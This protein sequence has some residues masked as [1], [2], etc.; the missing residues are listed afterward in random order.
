MKEIFREFLVRRVPGLFWSLKAGSQNNESEILK[1]IV[2]NASVNKSFVE[3]G[4]HAFQ[5]NSVCLTKKGFRGL[6]I[7]GDKENC[8]LANLVF[9]KLNYNTQAISHWITLEALEPIVDFVKCLGEDLGVL[10][11]DIDGND[12]WILKE[13]LNSFKPQVI[14]V[15]YNASMGPDRKITVPYLRDFDR[16]VSHNSGLYH[17]ASYS[18]F[19]DLLGQ[20]YFLVDNIE[21]V[22][23]V[24]IRNDI[25]YPNTPIYIDKSYKENVRR[26]LFTG[27]SLDEQWGKIKDLEFVRL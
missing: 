25:P 12:Y 18:A 14:C 2:E 26:T 23:L 17:G 20:D 1:G 11:V 27:W 4:F 9:G 5:Y 24:F 6:V 15:E 3:F 13:L 19:C 22:N 7:D 10:N 8:D 16:M 21:G